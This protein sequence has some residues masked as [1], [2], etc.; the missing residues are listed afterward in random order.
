MVKLTVI[1]EYIGTKVMELK[2]GAALMDLQPYS[3][4]WTGSKVSLIELAY[5]LHYC[6]MINPWHGRYPSDH[7]CPGGYL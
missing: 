4:I 7:Q 1:I 2:T 6:K 3:T 5:A